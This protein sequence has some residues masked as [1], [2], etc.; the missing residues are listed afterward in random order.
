MTQSIETH[1]MW[2]SFLTKFPRQLLVKGALVLGLVL[3][4]YFWISWT[5]EAHRTLA[6]NEN[7]ISQQQATIERLRSDI[8]N[9]T[10]RHDELEARFQPIEESQID[11][12]CSARYSQPI[13]AIEPSLPIVKEVVVYRDRQT[14]CPTIDIDQAE[15]LT[16][17]SITYRPSNEEVAIGVLDN[18]WRAYCAATNNED[19]VCTRSP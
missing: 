16:H 13:A 3:G 8:L 7:T 18:S 1:F 6:L 15:P 12:L 10:V 4:L 19:V 17:P 14:Q 11:L 2:T 9:Y 5:V